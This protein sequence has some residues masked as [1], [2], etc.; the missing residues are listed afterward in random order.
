MKPLDTRFQ[1]YD[2]ATKISVEKI[3]SKS[4]YGWK[5]FHQARMK[6]YQSK[7]DSISLI[8]EKLVVNSKSEKKRAMDIWKNAIRCDKS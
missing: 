6:M 1:N 4:F 2:I 5:K 8:W 7:T 3:L